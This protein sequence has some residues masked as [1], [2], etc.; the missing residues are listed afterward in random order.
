MH[1]TDEKLKEILTKSGVVDEKT[2]LDVK[3]EAGRSGQKVTD[4]LIGRDEISED[5]LNELLEA[6]YGVPVVDLKKVNIT[7]ETLEKIPEAYAK[8]K[9]LVL[10]ELDDKKKTG[11]NSHA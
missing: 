7:K 5:Y 4:V 10:Y 6:Y 3:Q 11:Q 8:S 2:F 9:S 1:I